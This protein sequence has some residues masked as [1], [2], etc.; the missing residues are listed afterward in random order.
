MA[1]LYY[2]WLAFLQRKTAYQRT[3][4][5]SGQRRLYKDFGNVFANDFMFWW[6]S[7]QLLFANQ[8]KV[9]TE[10]MGIGLNYWLDLR[11]PLNQIYAEIKA[12][13]LRAHSRLTNNSS[14]PAS[15]ARY[16][17]YKNV[18]S[19]MLR[20]TLKLWSLQLCHSDMSLC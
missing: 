15:S 19:H 1:S 18:S 10:E 17:I 3:C 14:T 11:K 7:H 4:L 5:Q 16:P 13:H 6:R 9:M 12:L 8:N 20:K 2:W